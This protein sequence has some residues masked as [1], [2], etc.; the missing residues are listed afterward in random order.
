MFAGYFGIFMLLLLMIFVLI[1]V[2]WLYIRDYDDD[3]D[4]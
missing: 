3:E 4:Y 2:L 1:G